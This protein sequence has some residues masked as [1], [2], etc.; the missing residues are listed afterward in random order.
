MC[1]SKCTD[2]SAREDCF[3]VKDGQMAVERRESLAEIAASTKIQVVL[4][5]I[6]HLRNCSSC[7]KQDD[8]RIPGAMKL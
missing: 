1:E 3:G 7:R 6:Q 8:C 2:N 5:K 4:H